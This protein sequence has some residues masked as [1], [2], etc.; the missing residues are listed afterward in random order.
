MLPTVLN[1]ALK[2][3]PVV[4][5]PLWRMSDGKDLVRVELTFHKVLPTDRYKKRAESRRQPAPS[6]GEWPRQPAAATRPTTPT[7][8]LTSARRRPTMERKMP[9]PP[10]H[11]SR[12]SKTRH[13]TWSHTEDSSHP[14]IANH[15]QTATSSIYLSSQPAE[16]VKDAVS[17]SASQQ[18][19]PYPLRQLRLLISYTWEV[20]PPGSLQ[21]PHDE[22]WHCDRQGP[23]SPTTTW[24]DQHWSSSF[25]HVQAQRQRQEICHGER[26]HQQVLRR[27]HLRA[28]KRRSW[29]RAHS[30]TSFHG[31]TT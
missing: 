8:R 7:N 31:T 23:T 28:H 18:E 17:N 4:G 27:E 3:Y 20:W 19:E 29:K 26:T 13:H 11:S 5:S 2:E 24:D 22:L 30:R 14:A 6:A 25:L 9:P 21:R 15:H 1:N 10:T 16:E 12:H